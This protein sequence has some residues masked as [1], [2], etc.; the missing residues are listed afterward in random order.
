MRRLLLSLLAALVIGCG[1][2]PAIVPVVPVPPPG[3][4]PEPTPDPTPTPTPVVEEITA[5][6]WDAVALG[7]TEAEVV[8]KAG[9]SRHR[10]KVGP[11]YLALGYWTRFDGALHYVEVVFGFDGKAASKNKW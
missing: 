6:A 11:G 10:G 8:A 7:M 2:T 4:T 9:P 3:P 5:A 1:C